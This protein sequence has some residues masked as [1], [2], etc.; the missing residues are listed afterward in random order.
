[1][2]YR[3]FT[4]SGEPTTPIFPP[5]STYSLTS[6]AAVLRQRQLLELLLV[7]LVVAGDVVPVVGV[8][9]ARGLAELA[10]DR[11]PARVGCLRLRRAELRRERVVQ[12]LLKRG[13]GLGRARALRRARVFTA[14]TS[15]A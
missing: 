6:A 4:C 12:L 5:A 15:T 14:F 11:T 2:S 10:G 7:V 13:A 9:V 3:F 8:S 1:L